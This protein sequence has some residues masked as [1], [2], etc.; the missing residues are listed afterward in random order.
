[1]IRTS[2]F[3]HHH[4]QL[5]S[6]VDELSAV[7]AWSES[8]DAAEQAAL[9][10]QEL[11]GQLTIHLELEDTLLYARLLTHP[12]AA[13]R[14]AAL[15]FKE[16]IVRF[17]AGFAD[18]CR[19]WQRPQTIG[20]DWATFVA[21]T[22]AQLAD[23]ARRVHREETVLFPLIDGADGAPVDGSDGSPAEAAP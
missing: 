13:V 16:E 11:K 5:R 22:R 6:T 17:A 23:L 2:T 7:L 19:T 1:M 9:R 3:R 12:S 18:Y 21:D 20:G 10:V 15:G 8:I 4:V 14:E